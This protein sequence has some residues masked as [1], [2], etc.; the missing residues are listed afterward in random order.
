MKIIIK[1]NEG[2]LSLEKCPKATQDP[3][4]NSKNKEHAMEEYD[5]GTPPGNSKE[6]CGNCVAWDV[7]PQMKKCIGNKEGLGYC[8]MHDFMCMEKKWCNTWAEKKKQK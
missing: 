5:Y 4:L 3:K 1:L 2:K 8:K 6:F 7:S